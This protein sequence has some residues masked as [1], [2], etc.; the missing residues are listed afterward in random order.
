MFAIYIIICESLSKAKNSSEKHQNDLHK[1]LV[2]A[3]QLV[4]ALYDLTVLLRKQGPL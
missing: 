4:P 2:T 1:S 3:P